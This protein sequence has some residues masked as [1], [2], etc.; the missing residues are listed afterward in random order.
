MVK[1]VYREESIGYR[2]K[3]RNPMIQGEIKRIPVTKRRRVSGLQLS[4]GS[5][6]DEGDLGFGLTLIG[7]S[8]YMVPPFPPR[9]G[10]GRYGCSR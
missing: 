2:V 3:A 9:R 7:A 8:T 6:E 1:L 4:H 10:E 5:R